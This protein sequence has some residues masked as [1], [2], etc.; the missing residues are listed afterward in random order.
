MVQAFATLIFA[1]LGVTAIGTI[2]VL[3]RNDWTTISRALGFGRAT[4]FSTPT[5]PRIRNTPARRA[6]M[7]RVEVP[8]SRMR[9]AA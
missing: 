5:P 2:T 9:V 1:A 8:Q 3:L 4:S 6:V 7:M